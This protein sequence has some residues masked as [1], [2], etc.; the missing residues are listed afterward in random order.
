MVV[1]VAGG[2]LAG[3][4]MLGLINLLRSKRK[5][6]APALILMTMITSFSMAE[7][8]LVMNMGILNTHFA[9][10]FRLLLSPRLIL[11]TIILCTALRMA[12]E[13]GTRSIGAGIG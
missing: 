5:A 8:L 7:Y 9:L 10:I 2:A 4:L 11:I 1:S 12:P 6:F 3:V 13:R